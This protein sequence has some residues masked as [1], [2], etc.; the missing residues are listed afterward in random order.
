MLRQIRMAPLLGLIVSCQVLAGSSL[1]TQVVQQIAHRLNLDEQS[2]GVS[3]GTQTEKI[4]CQ[5][6]VAFLPYPPNPRGGRVS[7][8]VRCADNRPDYIQATYRIMTKHWVINQDLSR[9]DVL[10]PHMLNPH[11]S[12]M[13][14][15][16]R[17]FVTDPS[18]YWGQQINRKVSKNTVLQENQLEAISLVERQEKVTVEAKGKGF[19]ISREGSSL[20][21]GSLGQRIKIRLEG[22][23]IVIATVIA[24]QRVEIDL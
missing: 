10:K 19:R 9:G 14:R 5:R 3:L 6:P 1:E 16:P 21:S 17:G 24:R 4:T 8:G 22:G 20:E 13:A 11:T 2:I 15:L 7:V 12:E 23:S 18:A